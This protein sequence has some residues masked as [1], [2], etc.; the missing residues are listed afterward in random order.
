[1]LE[2]TWLSKAGQDVLSVIGI[3]TFL[4]G[5]APFSMTKMSLV[6]SISTVI[7]LED[8]DM[9]MVRATV[10]MKYVL[11]AG[12]ASTRF[13]ERTVTMLSNVHIGK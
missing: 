11:G 7:R 10:Q 12:R 1:M 9:M 3:A 13:D 8:V 2:H 6:A 5:F 4:I